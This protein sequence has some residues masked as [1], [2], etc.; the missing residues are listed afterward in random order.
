[1]PEQDPFLT[2]NESISI[3]VAG[4]M[5]PSIHH[6]A[7]YK[8]VGILTDADL[9]ES[10]TNSEKTASIGLLAVGG[11]ITRSLPNNSTFST[12]AFSQFTVGRIRIQCTQQTYN[13]LTYD[14]SDLDRICEI[15]SAVFKTLN[16]TPVS[17]YGFN[18]SFHRKT[19]TEKVGAR[20]AQLVSSLGFLSE[21]NGERSAKIAY[22]LSEP[23]RVLNISVEQS[24]RA[25]DSVFV[26]MN[27]H[28]PIV[29]KEKFELFDL[30]PLLRAGLDKAYSDAQLIIRN[31]LT[32]LK[33]EGDD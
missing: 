2:A 4:V 3:V 17:A 5:N 10:D 7:W 21:R 29:P 33:S 18:F 27:V 14:P 22:T 13:V 1:M 15:A 20:F 26:G 12:P 31:V 11:D 19:G 9:S 32:A 23:P 28:N 30:A 16:H 6:P 8:L 25:P 24:V